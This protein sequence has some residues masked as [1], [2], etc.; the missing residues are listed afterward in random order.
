[1]ERYQRFSA[2]CF[3][4]I[5]I[6]NPN[7]SEEAEFV[8]LMAEILHRQLC[9]KYES[10]SSGSACDPLISTLDQHERWCRSSAIQIHS[11]LLMFHVLN[12]TMLK[13][14]GCRE[15]TPY[16]K[17]CRNSAIN[18]SIHHTHPHCKFGT[19]RK[20]NLQLKRS[21]HISFSVQTTLKGSKL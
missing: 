13:L 14:E 19:A 10:L 15:T 16:K 8:Q 11:E 7:A 4:P 3:K 1:M 17:W 6:Y 20:L 2:I 12:T 9:V 21:K 5:H 18:S